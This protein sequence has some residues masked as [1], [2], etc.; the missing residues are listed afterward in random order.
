MTTT[1]LLI[2]PA[3]IIT[4][5]PGQAPLSHGAVLCRGDRVEAIGPF[6]E[7]QKKHPQAKRLDGC[8]GVVMPGLING[9]H[10]LYSTF[11]RGMPIPA[12]T[13]L[14][15]FPEILEGIW[16]RLD[17][18]LDLDAVEAGAYP[19]VLDCVRWGATTIVDHH[20]SPRA[21]RGSLKALATVCENVGVR[22]ALCYE[23]TDRNGHADAIAGIE[24]NVAFATEHASHPRLRGLL[25][26]HASFTIADETLAA[27]GKMIPADLPIHIH[28]AE[29]AD[30]A[31][32]TSDQYKSGIL[33]RLERHGLLR[34]RS[35]LAHGTHLSNDELKRVAAAGAWIV[36]NPESNMNNAV[37]YFDVLRALDAGVKV[38]LGT[39]GMASNMLR[40][41]KAA[42][43]M[44]R[45]ARHDATVGFN[46]PRQLLLE[47]NRKLAQELFGQPDLGTIAVG[48]PA[49]LCLLDYDPP[50]VLNA[51][52]F[53][54][55]LVFG[56]TEAP[57]LATVSAGKVRY[58]R[59]TFEGVDVA[60]VRKR[61]LEAANRT[62]EWLAK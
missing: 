54:S 2:G 25:G 58:D 1:E 34:P 16:W 6:A 39:D 44:A 10:H 50:T 41:A 33:D 23:I 46:L 59:G 17:R 3:T 5:V 48:G 43:L 15:T 57:V 53:E 24:E 9:H 62:W 40:A 49:D 12:G 55:H 61:V 19:P 31:R 18:A 13:P 52:T 30:D 47:G 36:H 45:H 29:A 7:L 22:A 26:L 35:I 27:A 8:D 60:A 38:A 4:N 20:A 37:G 21:I 51:Q 11:A 14:R 42:Y 28:V 32:L 56:L